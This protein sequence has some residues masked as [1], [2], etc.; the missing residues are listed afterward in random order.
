MRFLEDFDQEKHFEILK[1]WKEEEESY[2]EKYSHL[3]FD[4]IR[5][6]HVL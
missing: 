5:H 6:K 2:L 4:P 1:S 3:P